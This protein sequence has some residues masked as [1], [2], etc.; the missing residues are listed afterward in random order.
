VK[1]TLVPS[2]VSDGDG[3][4]E[5]FLSSYLINDTVAIDAGSVGFLRPLEAQARVRHVLISHTHIDHVASLP[6]F[7]ENVYQGLP[8]APTIHGSDPVLR[9]LQD[10]VF[11]DR[12]WPDF[13]RLSRPEAPFL[14]LHRLETGQAIEV[15]GLHITPVPV[16]HVV[17]TNGFLIEDD[18]TAIVIASDTGPTEALWERVNRA[19]NLKAVFLEVTFPNHLAWL[20][21]AAK[22]LTPALFAEEM[23]KVRASAQFLAVHI[24]ARYRAQ[25]VRELQALNIPRLEIAEPGRVYQF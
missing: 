21:D 18:R 23:R 5:Q 15:E 1:V 11:N 7:L 24:K 4:P 25:V 3:E 12:I 8:D 2:A 17:P 9:G 19:S 6:I 20:A 22:H 16:N 14:R 13:V 10:D